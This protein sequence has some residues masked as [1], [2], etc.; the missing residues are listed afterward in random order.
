MHT[1][2][3]KDTGPPASVLTS[4]YS[5]FCLL[6]A[7]PWKV[8]EMLISRR[9]GFGAI[10]K[11]EQKIHDRSGPCKKQYTPF[12]D[13]DESWIDRLTSGME[14]GEAQHANYDHV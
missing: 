3:I 14:I 11:G 5:R 2:T 13:I 9:L 10:L 8:K 7:L 4:A 6:I 1:R 12:A